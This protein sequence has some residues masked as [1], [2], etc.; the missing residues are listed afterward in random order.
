MTSKKYKDSHAAIY[1]SGIVKVTWV[2][3]YKQMVWKKTHTHTQK[4]QKNK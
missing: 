1:S 3:A 2:L 4:K